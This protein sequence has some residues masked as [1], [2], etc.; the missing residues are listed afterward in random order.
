[1]RNLKK[2]LALVMVFALVLGTVASAASFTDIDADYSYVEEVELLADL[3]V[4]AGFPD[5]SYQ[6]EATITRVQA[7]AV[8]Y[9]ILTG[10]ANAAMYDGATKFYDVAASYWGTGYINYC[11]DI[12]AIGGYPDGSF[13]PDQAITVAEYESMLVRALGLTEGKTLSYPNGYLALAD[14]NLINE[15]VPSTIAANSAADR[16]LVSKLTYNT[17]VNATYQT[18]ATRDDPDPKIIEKIF[19]IVPYEGVIVGTQYEGVNYDHDGLVGTANISGITG[20]VDKFSFFDGTYTATSK[21]GTYKFAKVTADMVGQKVKMYLKTNAANDTNVYAVVTSSD[22]KVVTS[23]MAS[24]KND[25]DGKGDY[26]KVGD[27]KNY[28]TLSASVYV[29]GAAGVITATD[30]GKNILKTVTLISNDGNDKTIEYSFVK[31]YSYTKFAQVTSSKIYTDAVI[32]DLKQTDGTLYDISITDG[33]VEGDKILVYQNGAA[34]TVAEVLKC[35]AVE[36]TLDGISGSAAGNDLKYTFNGAT[37]SAVRAATTPYATSTDAA[38]LDSS[39]NLGKAAKFIIA[40]IFGLVVETSQGSGTV[41][42]Y[43]Y[44]KQAARGSGFD[45]TKNL[46][47]AVNT[48]G[49]TLQLTFATDVQLNG[50]GV[51]LKAYTDAVVNATGLP[52][53]DDLDD[54]V[55]GLLN[56]V[57]VLTINSSNEITSMKSVNVDDTALVAKTVAAGG[58]AVATGLGTTASPYTVSN[59]GKN[60]FSV[61]TKLLEVT[62]FG[63]ATIVS[64]KVD[65]SSAFFVKDSK[66]DIYVYV[67]TFPA[68]VANNMQMINSY[69][70]NDAYSTIRAAVVF[71]DNKPAPTTS[72][73][74]MV[75]DAGSL[76]SDTNGN[77][78]ANFKIAMNGE[79]KTMSTTSVAYT[80]AS[81]LTTFAT[82]TL[83]ALVGSVKAG[84]MVEFALTSDGKIA[85]DSSKNALKGLVKHDSAISF[86]TNVTENIGYVSDYSGNLLAVTDEKVVGS[87]TATMSAIFKVADDVKVYEVDDADIGAGKISAKGAVQVIKAATASRTKIVFVYDRSSS[88]DSAQKVIEIY[89]IK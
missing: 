49:E 68:T 34:K 45:A 75:L 37:K 60:P 28:V 63:G 8:I 46:V 7:A 80:D 59:L 31:E 32:I 62:G 27:V 86:G 20:T 70:K 51:A 12:G 44:L 21:S 72:V 65:D 38:K 36:A 67:G 14:A 61:S 9:R 3:G 35:D 54:N 43:Y 18:L 25:A 87:G 47:K 64:H 55:P 24:F 77:V 10:R 5:G 48:K 66:G 33:L 85:V 29:N 73:Y 82:G 89:V 79:V 71:A 39:S 57:Y 2:A 1:M 42:N 81:S 26:Y 4:L 13:K 52:G 6:P 19:K 50:A 78:Y 74:G 22:N 84:T 83:A 58:Y 17:M 69:S 41:A 15:D 53:S 16:G 11:A 56:Q 76:A 88:D 23:N 40:P 30:M